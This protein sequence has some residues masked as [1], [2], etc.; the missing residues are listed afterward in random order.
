[1]VQ[2][3]AVAHDIIALLDALEFACLHFS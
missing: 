1:V 2:G 3:F